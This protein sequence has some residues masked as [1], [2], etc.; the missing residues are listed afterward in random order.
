MAME[1]RTGLAVPLEW[2]LQ[3]RDPLKE[4]LDVAN[5]LLLEG[6]KLRLKALE[7]KLVCLWVDPANA[8]L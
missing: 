7:E 5:L 3:L 1:L 8:A 2:G 6:A 4:R